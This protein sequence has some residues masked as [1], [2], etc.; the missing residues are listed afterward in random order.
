MT[1]EIVPKVA[2]KFLNFL[3]SLT[4]AHRSKCAVL[5]LKTVVRAAIFQTHPS[6]RKFKQSIDADGFVPG[7]GD[8]TPQSVVMYQIVIETEPGLGHFETTIKGTM[9]NSK[10]T[11][12]NSMMNEIRQYG[13]RGIFRGMGNSTKSS[14]VQEFNGE[15]NEKEISRTNKYGDQPSCVAKEFPNLRSYCYCL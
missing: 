6:M 5:K 9:E 13:L 2:V 3:N 11:M 15:F 10:G 12:E 14:R 4:E 1:D 8:N 7:F